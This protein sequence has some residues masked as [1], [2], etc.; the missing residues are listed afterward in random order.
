MLEEKI[1]SDMKEALKAG[2]KD[3]V[4]TLRMVM[5]EMKNKKIEDGTEELDDAKVVSLMQKKARQHKES[6]EKFREGG[7][8][9]LAEKETREL[10]V[11]EEYLPEEM[12]E[13][14]LTGIISGV[15]E[16]TGASSARDM[17]RVMKEVISRVQGRAD[18]KVISRIVK[19]K[20]G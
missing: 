18:G 15:I 17:G 13:E 7:R 20:L 6:I 16:E 1:Q 5:S 19:E 3:K 14:E 11:I 2:D 10:A 4:S 12:A 9:D 8:D